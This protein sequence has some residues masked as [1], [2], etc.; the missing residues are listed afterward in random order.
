VAATVER[1]DLCDG[2]DECN[3]VNYTERS[4][5]RHGE[6]TGCHCGPQFVVAESGQ[7]RREEMNIIQGLYYRQQQSRAE[8]FPQELCER[9]CLGD[10]CS[11]LKNLGHD[12]SDAG[13]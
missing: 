2:D 7:E 8:V 12:K 11:T 9:W 13:G 3:V 10:S 4:I 6:K 5:H 1:K